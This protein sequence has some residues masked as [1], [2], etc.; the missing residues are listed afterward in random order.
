MVRP[1]AETVAEYLG[2]LT[3]E[4][5]A[6]LETLRSLVFQVAPDAVGTM[7]YGMPAYD[8]RGRDLCQFASQKR[9][10]SLYLDPRIVEKYRGELEGLSL[11]KGCVRFRKLDQLPLE[12]IEHMLR[13][14]AERGKEDDGKGQDRG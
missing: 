12:T 2:A 6:T 14:I 13:E 10:V 8:V 11:G 1:K 9:Y 3:P 4:R 7:R 5:R